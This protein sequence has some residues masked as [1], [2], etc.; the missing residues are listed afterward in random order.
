MLM[1]N[2]SA[3]QLDPKVVRKRGEWF[4]SVAVLSLLPAFFLLVWPIGIDAVWPDG[5]SPLGRAS[6]FLL[7][8]I[9]VSILGRRWIPG[10][11]VVAII[12]TGGMIISQQQLPLF[13]DMVAVQRLG[14]INSLEITYKASQGRYGTIEDLIAAKLLDDT[15]TDTKGGYNYT[16]TLDATGS[17]YTAEAVP[18]TTR[19]P[20]FSAMTWKHAHRYAYYI[21][22]DAVVRYSKHASLAPDGQ[23]G[24]S[25]Q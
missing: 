5:Y 20:W 3:D 14:N 19:K 4:R 16:I 1:P 24:S 21:L 23:A 10:I 15:F 18:D 25:V 22:P 13:Y 9:G 8:S 6:V 7:L 2:R 17:D 12:F 11:V